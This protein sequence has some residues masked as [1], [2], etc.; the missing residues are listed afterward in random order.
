MPPGTNWVSLVEP[1]R[2]ML[3]EIAIEHDALFIDVAQ[4]LLDRIASGQDPDFTR[5]PYRQSRSWHKVIGDGHLNAYGNRLVA[6]AFLA[7]TADLRPAPARRS[8]PVIGR[9]RW[10]GTLRQCV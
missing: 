7:A 8:L 10:R 1:V 5:V 4:F 6:E 2:A 3:R 9:R